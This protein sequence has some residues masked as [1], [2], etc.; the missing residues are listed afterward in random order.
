[1]T[2]FLA[3][4]VGE[5]DDKMQAD[6]ATK[7]FEATIHRWN[8]YISTVLA[9]VPA[10]SAIDMRWAAVKSVQ[11]LMYNWRSVP[12]LPDGVLPSYIGYQGGMWSWDSYLL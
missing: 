6:E 4:S 10:K 8:G 3:I 2:T 12:G 9:S 11:T 7:S 5:A 1:M